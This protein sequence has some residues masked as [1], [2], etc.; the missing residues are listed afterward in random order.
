MSNRPRA[1]EIDDEFKEE[2]KYSATA[3]ENC[4]HRHYNME[5]VF[6]TIFNI[7]KT[8]SSLE[9]KNEAFDEKSSI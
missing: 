1:R 6:K 3:D 7:K 2:I 5:T 9:P 4:A 8:P